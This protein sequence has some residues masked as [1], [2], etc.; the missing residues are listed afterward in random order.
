MKQ[1]ASEDEA[2]SGDDD[3]E[4]GLPQ[5]QQATAWHTRM[6]IASNP[7]PTGARIY[8]C[9]EQ[10]T[11]IAEEAPNQQ[12]MMNAQTQV[13]QLAANDQELYHYCFFQLMV[14]LD[15]RLAVGGPLMSEVATS[16]FDT[17]RAM[18]ILARGLDALHG[19]TKY[20]DYLQRRYV[21]I[22]KDTFGRD[23]EVVGP[24]MGS[25]RPSFGSSTPVG[26]KPA[27]AASP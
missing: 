1:E 13:T 9:I 18:W 16:F 14:R 15:D 27:G 4:T 12:D 2:S 22:S 19:R 10:V 11:R 20:F 26:A 5:P 8:S 6:L 17:M 24:P 21:Q 25:V 23:V 3:Q 7:Q